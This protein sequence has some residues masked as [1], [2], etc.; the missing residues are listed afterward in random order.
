MCA[1]LFHPKMIPWLMM[2]FW[3][4]RFC[5]IAKRPI[6]KLR[7]TP[8]HKRSNQRFL[9]ESRTLKNVCEV[10][11]SEDDPLAD[12]DVLERA[13]L[14]HCQTADSQIEDNTKTQTVLVL[15]TP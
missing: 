3:N 15:N 5:V 11:P 8:R 13:L 14:R 12:D 1:K 10:I 2:M 7:T 6:A 4:G 9:R